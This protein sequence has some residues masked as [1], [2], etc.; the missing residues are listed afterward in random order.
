MTPNGQKAARS[1]IVAVYHILS[2]EIVSCISVCSSACSMST[3]TFKRLFLDSPFFAVCVIRGNTRYP[4]CTIPCRWRRVSLRLCGIT[5][6]PCLMRPNST[7]CGASTIDR[8]LSFLF[9]QRSRGKG[10][11]L[12]SDPFDVLGSVFSVCAVLRSTKDFNSK[13][14]KNVT[15]RII[16][17]LR[18]FVVMRRS[19]RNDTNEWN[20]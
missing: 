9:C 16:C 14:A 2:H 4:R 3:R 18:S 11:L 17:M 6:A 15:R 19:M 7:S 8:A 10:R 12:F 1:H 20:T 13:R 5:S